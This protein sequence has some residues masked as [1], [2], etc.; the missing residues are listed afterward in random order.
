[1]T[2]SAPETWIGRSETVH[3][4]IS[5]NLVKRI[6]ATLGEPA[7]APGT[8]LP[9]LW[10]WAFFQDAVEHSGL[11]GD[12]HPARGGFLPPADNRNRMWAGGRLEF[13]HP[14]RVDAQVSRR[15]T[16]LNVQEK[17]G[18]TGALLFVT[19]QHEYVQDGQ[20]ALIEEQDIVYREPSPPK[21]GGTEPMPQGDWH[22]HVQPTPT[23][24]FR[25]SAVT[26]NG[27]RIHYDWPYVTE[28]EGYPGLVVHGPLIATLNV[29]AFVRA[30]PQLTVRRFS[31]RGVRPLIC[32]DAF[33]VGGRLIGEGKAQVWAGNQAG[34]AQVGEIEFVQ[35]ARR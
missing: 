24:L 28:T 19:V 29:Q 18:R 10:H 25:Y 15:S 2:T 30:N 5:H 31:F 32:P 9:E 22:L 1:M 23:L 7:P 12:G 33:D 26:F 35:E 8:P 4:C 6:A 11:G 16:I 27:H 20:Q 34:Q 17:H 3:D 14:L 13:L 21:L